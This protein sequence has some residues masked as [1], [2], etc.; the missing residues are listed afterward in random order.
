MGSIWRRAL[1]AGWRAH[2]PRRR[3]RVERYIPSE[4]AG[5]I[6]AASEDCRWTQRWKEIMLFKNQP[7]TRG[8][9]IV[10]LGA[11]ILALTLA[12]AG[13]AIYER[14]SFR[15]TT[16]SELTTLADM[17]GANAAASL[18]SND[19][20]T[21]REILRAL[22]VEHNVLAASL[23]DDKREM[24][25]EY[26]R[27]DLA[28]N[29]R[30]PVWQKAGARFDRQTISLARGVSLNGEA[31]GSIVILSDLSEL[32]ASLREFAQIS[33]LVL[34][35]SVLLTYLASSRLLRRVSDPIVELA[36]VAR[37]VSSGQDYSL[38]G[39]PPSNDEAGKLVASFS[40]ML[41]GIQQRDLALRDDEHNMLRALIDNIPD[42][43]YVKDVKSRFV[44]ANSYLAHVVG[45]ETPQELLGKTD[46][47][48]YPPEL[49]NAFYE[50]EQNVIRSGQPL[51]N[52]E[53]KGVD[54]AGN[55]T[56]IL[57]T[58]V[59]V[60]N[61][62]GLVIGIAGIGRDISDR[63]KME[64]ALRE[65]GRK[66]RDRTADLQ[67]EVLERIEAE[68]EMRRA[69]DA[70]EL[71]SRAK[72]EFLANMSHEIRTPLNGV[73]GMTELALDTELTPEQHDYLETIDLSANTLLT[74]INDI[75]DFSKIEAGKVELEAIDF[76]LRDCLEETLKTLALR[77]DEEGLELL[78]DIAADVPE[79]VSGDAVHLRQIILNL[80]GNAIKFTHQGEVAL[81]VKTIAATEDIRTLQITVADT[82]IGIPPEKQK[83]IFDPFTQADTSTTRNYG[84]TGLGLT[85]S[86]R[87]I[88]MMG[89]RI[90]LESEVG[91]GS[92]FHFTVQLRVGD[93]KPGPEPMVPVEALRNMRVLV[94]DDNSTNRRIVQEMLKRWEV[95]S[96]AVEGGQP[97]LAELVSAQQA[98]QPYQLLL[99]D[100]HMP[101]MDGFMLVEEIRHRTG[102]EMI[103]IMMLT[104]TAHR[105]DA[106]RCR[107]L[108][109]ASYLFK[110][111]RKVELL[112]AVLAVLGQNRTISA[113]APTALP[114]TAVHGKRLNILLAEDNRVNQVVA[115]RILEK[116]GHTITVAHDGSEALSLLA[117]RSFD[118]VLMDIQ[119]PEMDGLAATKSIRLRETRTHSHLPIIAMTAHAMKGDR[120]CCLEAG[121]D[122]YVSKPI[123]AKELGLAIANVM[124]LSINDSF[125]T[126]TNAH[127]EGSSSIRVDFDLRK[128]LDRLGGEETLLH[129]VIEIFIDQAPKHIDTLRG[130][131]AQGNAEAVEKTAHC[132]KGELAYLGISEVSQKARELEELGR[133]HDLEPASRIFASFE[134]DISAIVAAMRRANSGNS[135]AASSG[136]SH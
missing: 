42:F 123:S 83:F 28:T 11:T 29:F 78:C 131:L 34:L 49:A 104:S 74:V 82:G 120:E 51:C 27:S 70:A 35:V 67:Q 77:A 45:V 109:I 16:V 21:G 19:K 84:G 105:G 117:A 124:H 57:T 13:F 26:R 114:G 91:R 119:M 86:A 1:T 121:M 103:A 52:R 20:K 127:L 23:Y 47:D 136:V 18:T 130:A 76:N 39:V 115:T 92:Q 54:G 63:K 50:D 72:S 98:G 133:K 106:E 113:A 33:V 102:L 59:P 80:V 66:L 12:C 94:V 17:L 48:F 43:M 30:A 65:A 135:L 97:A 79:L 9:A 38:R 36:E 71:A 96:T 88:S 41:D 56:H 62:K 132:M 85:I 3:N 81:R 89:G 25:A 69:K 6:V 110:P 68:A 95:N 31:I 75:L 101:K 53:E 24:F 61:S 37:R 134:T 125:S 129:E 44:V 15:K 32:R 99:T 40:Q 55:E 5:A 118:L 60:R 93:K 111:I 8:L 108:G 4:Q 14:E 22:R 2:V 46:F 7:I 116:M 122:G 107:A 100:M 10:T 64:D 126:S 112:T 87:L 128:I 73:I 90:W 58:K